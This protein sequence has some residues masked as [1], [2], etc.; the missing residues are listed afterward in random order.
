[1]QLSALESVD[2]G[3][4]GGYYD[5]FG[6]FRDMVQNHLLQMMMLTA[7]EPPG[8]FDADLIR[9]E[10]VRLLHRC[11]AIARDDVVSGQ[12][13]GYNRPTAPALRCALRPTLRCG[14]GWIMNAGAVCPFTCAPARP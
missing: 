14:C 5:N 11:A 10:K 7:I 12:Y 8:R 2:V 3:L 1:M 6:V 13:A 4:R 9:D